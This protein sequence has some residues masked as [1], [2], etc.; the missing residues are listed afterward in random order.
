MKIENTFYALHENNA[1]ILY[2]L[3]IRSFYELD[4]ACIHDAALI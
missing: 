1:S 2:T 3:S 4:T